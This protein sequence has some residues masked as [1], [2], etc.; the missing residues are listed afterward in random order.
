MMSVPMRNQSGAKSALRIQ[1]CR[2][3]V[4]GVP[5]DTIGRGADR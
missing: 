2:S 3:P 1:A 5:G 4:N